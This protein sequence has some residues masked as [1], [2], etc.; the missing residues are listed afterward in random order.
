MFLPKKQRHM[1]RYLKSKEI[2][3][4]KYDYCVLKA[5]QSKV[6]AFS[7]YLDA[8]SETWDVLVLGD[9]EAVMPLPN[10]KKYRI[11]YIFQPNWIQH[12]GIFSRSN[13]TDNQRA[14]FIKKI[15]KKFTLIDYYTNFKTP[16]A[17]EQ[18]NYILTLKKDYKS[19]FKAFSKGRKSSINQA[20]KWGLDIREIEEWT[21][22]ITLF[23]QNKGLNVELSNDAYNVLEILLK[24]SKDLNKLKILA[25]YSKDNELLGGAFFIISKTRITYLFSA[26][27]TQGRDLQAMSLIIDTIIKN[28]S[29]S[30]FIFDFEGSMLTGVAKFIRSF[31]PQKEAYY[32]YKKWRLF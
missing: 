13:L 8:V 32:H 17:Q 14:V 5:I 25:A 22:I 28:H 4:K 3:F 31:G 11:K 19:I 20:K 6:Y 12:L 15:P 24:K 27:N 7:W 30:D 26:I 23:K 10:R 21:S 2:D 29:E 1:I 18:I 16:K 9:Y